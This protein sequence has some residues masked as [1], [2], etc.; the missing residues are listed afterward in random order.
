MQQSLCLENTK[1]ILLQIPCYNHFPNQQ[2]QNSPFVQQ[3]HIS[4]HFS[5]QQNPSPH[6][7]QAPVN[8]PFPTQQT[9]PFSTS[10]TADNINTSEIT[11]NLSKSQETLFSEEI[12]HKPQN[13]F[14]TPKQTDTDK[15]SNLL[16]T[17]TDLNE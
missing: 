10:I 8:S 11:T 6:F 12:S 15:E 4:S 3:V 7:Q 5:T 1:K 2:F 16:F 13:P 17:Q 14:H 9:S